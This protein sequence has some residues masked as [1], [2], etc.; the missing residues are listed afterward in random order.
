MSN[1]KKI[2]LVDGSSYLF[3]AFYALPELSNKQG[4]PTG[5]IFGIINM[6]KRLPHQL[7]TDYIAVIFDAKG[8]NFRHDLYPEYKAHRKVIPKEWK[9]KFL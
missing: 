5:L 3:R 4:E 9:Y 6:L 7:S 1:I 8:K 2:V